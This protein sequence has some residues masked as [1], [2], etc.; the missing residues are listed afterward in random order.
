M[1]R[2]FSVHW[3][4]HAPNSVGRARAIIDRLLERVPTWRV[5]FEGPGLYVTCPPTVSPTD[6]IRLDRV[7]VILGTVFPNAGAAAPDRASR[8]LKLNE[9]QSEQIV[10]TRGRALISSFWGSYVAFLTDVDK[11]STH[12]LRGPLTSI[13]CF[14]VT[15]ESACCFFSHLEDLE[16]LDLLQLNVNWDVI[17]AQAAAADFIGRETAI[18]EVT[19]VEGGECVETMGGKSTR[20]FYW[21]PC[22]IAE[23]SDIRD[24]ETAVDAVRTATHSCVQSWAARYGR[25]VHTLSGGLD[26]SISASC[27]RKELSRDEMICINYFTDNAI[28]DERSYARDVARFVDVELVEIEREPAVDLDIFRHCAK[29]AWPM[30]DFSGHGQHRQEVAISQQHGAAA[31]FS[32]EF[33]DNIFEQGAGLDGA[34]DYV[35][36]FGL[37]PGLLRV[38]IECGLR[39]NRSIWQVLKRAVVDGSAQRDA[40]YFS[41]LN[42]IERELRAP[43]SASTLMRG[44]ALESVRRDSTR[45]MHPWMERIAGVPPAKFMMIYGLYAMGAH[46]P[47]FALDGDPPLVAPLGSQP[48]VEVCLRV[49]SCFCIRGGFDRAVARN[50]FADSLPSS[51]VWRTTKGT[52]EPWTREV[53]RRNQTFLKEFLLDGILVSTGILDAQRVA[54]AFSN[55]VTGSR[56][57]VGDL[58]E[59]LYIEAW[60]RQW[61]PQRHCAVA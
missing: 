16:T 22:D 10:R 25:I 38:A 57:F 35:R 54:A 4:A 53:I 9:R 5:A 52:P 60:L 21:H 59:Q 47:P 50:A 34:A 40:S 11:A 1:T 48:L 13:K 8:L 42:Y 28:G 37:R 32:G 24:F 44:E 31:I 61:T 7:G 20:T 18:K 51:V 27:A 36:R 23:H 12:V 30:L 56:A 41:S 6:Q 19:A 26:S 29:T 45:F 39:R 14:H 2:F 3:N 17:R 33:G 43:I 55:E 46:E 15:H 49:P 58:I